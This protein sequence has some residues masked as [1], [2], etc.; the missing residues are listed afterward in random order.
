MVGYDDNSDA[1]TLDDDD[2]LTVGDYEIAYDSGT[3]EWQ[4]EYTPSGDVASVPKNQS[5]SLF[6]TDFADALAGQALADDGTLHSSIENAVGAASGWV[7]VG[8]GTF[9]EGVF[10]SKDDIHIVGS[11]YDTL[12]SSPSGTIGL[13]LGGSD[14]TVRNLSV[15][16]P[17]DGGGGASAIDT[18]T[19]GERITIA[20]VHVRQAEG[21]G[22]RLSNGSGHIVK[23]CTII[24]ADTNGISVNTPQA[25][26]Q[27]C[28]VKQ[29]GFSGIYA[30]GD[31]TIIAN[32]NSVN[33]GQNGGYDGI[34]IDSNDSIV[35]GCVSHSN[36]REGIKI[37][38]AISNIIANNR[39]VT[40]NDAATNTKLDGNKTGTMN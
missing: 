8:P 13:H 34:N 20:N 24:N 31:E 9:N 18:A 35:I 30:N 12:V 37:K 19:G 39:T 38:G 17:A 26:I 36:S 28:T 33:N 23:N 6:P 7:F 21:D 3:N 14:M 40:I 5:G 15:E 2:V 1:L 29:S 10:T 11:G 16:S 4:A 25:V 22:I 27:S 32:C